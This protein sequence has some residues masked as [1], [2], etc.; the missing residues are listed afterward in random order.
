MEEIYMKV[1]V[2]L[3][4][5]AGEDYPAKMNKTKEEF[6]Q[7][8]KDIVSKRLEL[9]KDKDV[10]EVRFTDEEDKTKEAITEARE[11]E[12]ALVLNEVHNTICDELIG[13]VEMKPNLKIAEEDKISPQYF[14]KRV[15]KRLENSA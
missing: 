9:R 5:K 1:I 2:Q 12:R 4:E 6:I 14:V 11:G 3:S 13:L 8:M 10:V 15:M 7:D